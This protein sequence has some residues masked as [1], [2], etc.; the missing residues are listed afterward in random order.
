VRA[1][2]ET[3]VTDVAT[4]PSRDGL[5]IAAGVLHYRFWPD[6][7]PT[8][9][10]LL[11]QSRPP[12]EIMVL[13]HASGDGSVAKI[14]EAYPQLEVVELPENRGA[15]AGY[16]QLLRALLTKDADAV[17]ALTDDIELAPDALE[18]LAARLVADSGL[19][20]VGP[21]AAHR[22][23]PELIF[24]AGGY[25]DARTWDFEFREKPPHVSDWKG[26]PPQRCDFLGTAGI[27]MRTS[28]GRE[29]EPMVEH[30]YHGFDDVDYTLQ[31]G[32]KGW[33]LECVPAAVSWRDIGDASGPELFTPV[34]PYLI[35]R[36]RLGV[37]ARKAPRRML[38]REMVRVVKWVIWDAVRPRG[39][40]R[41]ELGRRLRGLIDFSRGRWGPPPGKD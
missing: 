37:I 15:S 27:L 4:K 10:K 12:D 26:R 19:G 33:K 21:L 23:E 28:A 2:A 34:D 8:I 7:R 41:A 3:A 13:D 17:F 32:P 39:G 18:L 40:S 31:F 36:N 6:V 35:V 29:I 11:E 1:Q 38:V 14:R 20:A 24:Y 5:R 30:F 22:R 9:D 16:S 25:I